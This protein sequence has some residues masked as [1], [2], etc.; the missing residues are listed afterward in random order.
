M[1]IT[2]SNV[3]IPTGLTIK[4]TLD[5]TFDTDLPITLGTVTLKLGSNPIKGVASV[6]NGLHQTARFPA[7]SVPI[8]TYD[9]EILVMDEGPPADYGN[10]SGYAVTIED[11]EKVYTTFVELL[12]SILRDNP[13]VDID[14]R[15]IQIVNF[16]HQV[17]NR[18]NPG[19]IIVRGPFRS[20]YKTVAKKQW[21]MEA[22]ILVTTK[23]N[24]RGEK[25]DPDREAVEAIVQN[26]HDALT[27][28]EM[29]GGFLFVPLQLFEFVP[30]IALNL[31]DTSF[32]EALFVRGHHI[33]LAC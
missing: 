21:D 1:T 30:T 13:N 2:I 23:A 16:P 20:W 14:D 22:Q 28:K 10:A 9:I 19:I 3:V 12:R 32:Y 26:V 4:D 27:Q 7:G 17:A 25:D 15:D 24:W 33:R 11:S 6:S 29:M 5:I 18:K 8:G 31:N